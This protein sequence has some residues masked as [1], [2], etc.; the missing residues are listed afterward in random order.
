[1]KLRR[2]EALVRFGVII[3]SGFI[4]SIIF[5]I[6]AVPLLGLWAPDIMSVAASFFL[7]LF[8]V[9]GM[10]LLAEER[11]RGGGGLLI[12]F[13]LP[14]LMALVDNAVN[15]NAVWFGIG[16]AAGVIGAVYWIAQNK[17]DSLASTARLGYKLF[18][19]TILIQITAATILL[20]NTETY[21]TEPIIYLVAA[22]I[23][24][25]IMTYLV[26]RFVHGIRASNVFIFGPSNS[27]KTLLMLALYNE[28]VKNLGGTANEVIIAAD[29]KSMQIGDLLAEL[30]RGTLPRSTRQGE[31][32]IYVFSGKKMGIIPVSLTIID[33]AGE[34]TA[35]I[36]ERE[37]KGA[38]S[39]ISKEINVPE[40]VLNEEIGNPT[41]IK[42]LHDKYR[43]EVGRVL[44][45]V[46]LAYIYKNLLTSGKVLFLVDGDHMVRFH[47]GGRS[48]LIDNCGHYSRI[49]KLCGDDKK[50]GLVVTKTDTFYTLNDYGRELDAEQIEQDIYKE[51]FSEIVTFQEINNRALDM[52]IYFYATSAFRTRQPITVNSGGTGTVTPRHIH[53]WRIDE[54]V[55]FGF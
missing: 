38:I 20:L 51:W 26:G 15:F 39:A 43:S 54:I 16:C 53:P 1:M 5:S 50:Y 21:S 49:M 29:E 8:T 3:A 46:V 18:G 45:Q 7:G 10:G 6:L 4:I 35:N 40:E 25:A 42:G 31:L 9:S 44:D 24:F 48:E 36:N 41:Y 14:I 22:V 52:P 11:S 33:Y 27:G 13:A 32:G 55:R 17:F 47:N 19:A 23:L 2:K 34:H 30:D 28:F 37:Y 12:V